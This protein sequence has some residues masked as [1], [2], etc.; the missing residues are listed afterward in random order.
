[1]TFHQKS[2]CR[3]IR[4][5]S[6]IKS[7]SRK[8]SRAFAWIFDEMTNGNFGNFRRYCV[9]SVSISQKPTKLHRKLYIFFCASRFTSAWFFLS[10]I[11]SLFLSLTL[12]II[13]MPSHKYSHSCLE[14]RHKPNEHNIFCAEFFW[15]KTRWN[16]LKIN[17]KMCGGD[18][19]SKWK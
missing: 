5:R 8:W 6:R 11:Q 2:M 4:H 7:S 17:Q 13:T 19:Q 9:L 3:W 10:I 1:M 15:R 16:P 18:K 12:C 14:F